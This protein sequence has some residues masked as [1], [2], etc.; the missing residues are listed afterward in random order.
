MRL[1]SEDVRRETSHVFT[2]RTFIWYM[3]STRLLLGLTFLALLTGCI[4]VRQ[5][6]SPP[7]E[8]SV[9]TVR[10]TDAIELSYSQN[11][12][13]TAGW[14]ALLDI[15]SETG[16]GA[17]RVK[18]E[19]GEWPSPIVLRLYLVGLE[20]LRVTAGDRV[21]QLSVSSEPE[22]TIYQS[23]S[24]TTGGKPEQTLTPESPYWLP[25]SFGQGYFE[26]GLSPALLDP[27]AGAVPV[28]AFD[29]NWIDFYR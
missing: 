8:I 26:V 20:Q 4:G 6:V 10:Q 25:V 1:Q 24:D 15:T 14:A 5:S 29:L 9:T 13:S 22:R 23:L 3:F 21:V 2:F 16:I 12:I 19:A 28:L 11:A 18:L 17:G 27:A 7:P